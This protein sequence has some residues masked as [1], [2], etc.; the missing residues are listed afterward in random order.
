MWKY[1]FK[2]VFQ[3]HYTNSHLEPLL[4][5]WSAVS[6]TEL[7]WVNIGSDNGLAPSGSKPL[8]EPMKTHLCVAAP[9]HQA[10]MR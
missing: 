6:V 9:H 7:S 5:N 4:W 3:T 1:F 8:F 2:Y 10:T